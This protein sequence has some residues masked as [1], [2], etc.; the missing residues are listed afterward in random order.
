MIL[1]LSLLPPLYSLFLICL[2]S[3]T[4]G[5]AVELIVAIFALRE[6]LVRVVQIRQTS[7]FV[8]DFAFHLISLGILYS[9]QTSLLGSILSNMLLVLGASFFCGDLYHKRQSCAHQTFTYSFLIQFN[10][11]PLLYLMLF[12]FLRFNGSRAWHL[13]LSAHVG[14]LRSHAPATYD[15]V[16][17]DGSPDKLHH[18]A[19]LFCS[20]LLLLFSV[21]LFACTSCL[22]VYIPSFFR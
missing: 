5:N 22:A 8:L 13:W 11:L 6:G 19:L 3:A 21:V 20:A 4:F 16:K 2:R 17:Q 12:C 18:L 10:R 15:M 1:I 7:W 9:L 14:V